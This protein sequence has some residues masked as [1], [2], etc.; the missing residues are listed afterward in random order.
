VG[1]VKKTAD[2]VQAELTATLKR[3]QEK[4]LRLRTEPI[5]QGQCSVCRTG[6]SSV[7]GL[8]VSCFNEFSLS[9]EYARVKTAI[10]D[11]QRRVALEKE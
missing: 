3:L 2:E 6:F 5:T 8:C 11:W 7:G 9:P 4:G 10:A 1:R